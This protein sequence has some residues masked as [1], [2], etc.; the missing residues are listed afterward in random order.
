MLTKLDLLSGRE[1]EDALFSIIGRMR[2]LAPGAPPAHH[3]SRRGDRGR[4]SSTPASTIPRPNRQCAHWLNAEAYGKRRHRH[5]H[6]V[7]RHDDHIRSFPSP[8]RA[9]I[10]PQGLEMFID[11]V[12]SFHGANML[13]MKGIVKLADDPDRPVVLHGVQHVFH[14]PVRLI[15]L[16][17]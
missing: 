14:P 16:A 15:A 6:D 12:R 13:R 11:L 17:R 2:K 4:A 9:P 7:S 5:H 10:S 1:G 8:R 3:P